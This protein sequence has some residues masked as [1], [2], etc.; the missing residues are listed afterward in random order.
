MVSLGSWVGRCFD[1]RGYLMVSL[2]RKGPALT[3]IT[4]FGV[5]SDMYCNRVFHFFS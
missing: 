2:V 3:F 5:K 4:T 1:E